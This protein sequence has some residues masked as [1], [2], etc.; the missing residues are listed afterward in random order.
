MKLYL[1][2]IEYTFGLIKSGHLFGC[3]LNV[4]RISTC[5][6]GLKASDRYWTT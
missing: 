4:K 5:I 1:G 2:I 3:L 6:F